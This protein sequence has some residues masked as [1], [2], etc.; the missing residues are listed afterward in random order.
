MYRQLRSAIE[1]YA[2][3]FRAEWPATTEVFLPDN[4]V[5][6]VGERFVQVDLAKSFK[7]LVGAEHREMFR[8]RR[9]AL[10]AARDVF[11]KGDIAESIVRFAQENEFPD[12]SGMS[13]RGLLIREDLLDYSARVE[14]PVMVRYRG[15]DVY[16]CGPWTQ[17]P[18]FLQQLNLLEGH[19]LAA[20]GHNSP[21]YIHLVTEAAKLAFADRERWYGDP[22]FSAVPLGILL[23]KEYAAQ[24]RALID[25]DRASME[26]RPGNAAPVEPKVHKGD[27]R[28][29]SGDTT[30]LDVVDKWG[31]MLA[32]TP[33]GGWI[34]S[35]PLIPGLGF[36]LGTRLQ[37]FSLDPSHPNALQPGKRP[38]TTLTPSLAMKD[39]DPFMVF[40][41]PGG[42]QQDQWSLQLFLNHVDF[43]MNIQAAIDAPNFHTAHF[44]SSFY[45][46][47]AEPGSLVLEGRI[48]ESTR[49]ALREKGHLVQIAGDWSNG[50]V[51]AIRFDAKSGLLSGAASPRLETGYAMGW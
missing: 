25:P 36:P 42:D 16:K 14:E 26:L 2:D 13:N 44:P 22:D 19:D 50:R 51:L 40:G 45:P 11:Y 28:A 35:S 29:Y 6:E 20:L 21:A 3:R 15:H 41:T 43:G 37:M 17:G 9:E 49:A 27:P 8:G 5:P 39:G 34:A 18:V 12:A 32:A 7:K 38:R 24:R 1:M 30:H 47:A 23:S 46:R 48:P 31:N 33:S 10:Q 4:R